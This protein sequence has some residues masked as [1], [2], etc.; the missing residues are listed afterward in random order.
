MKSKGLGDTVDKITTATGIK[1]L[2]H[3]LFGEDCGC[4]ERK[5]KLN[6]MFPYRTEFLNKDEYEYLSKFN[7]SSDILNVSD[8]KTLLKIYN[9]VFNQ[10]K[11]STTCSSCWKQII[12]DLKKLYDEH[13]I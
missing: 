12:S 10:R 3:M 8:Q 13:N 9:R 7:F 11:E 5:N 2:V 1:T 6:S 4:E